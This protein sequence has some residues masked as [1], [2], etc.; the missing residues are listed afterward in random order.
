MQRPHNE[1]GEGPLTRSGTGM[2]TW[3]VW[4]SHPS[5]F[6]LLP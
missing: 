5:R 4:L 2:L 6:A 1:A 3:L